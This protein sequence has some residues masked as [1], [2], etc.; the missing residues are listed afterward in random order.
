[1]AKKYDVF[2]SYSRKDSRIAD[3]IYDNLSDAGVICFIDRSDI[4]LGDEYI[5]RLYT[6]INESDIVLYLASQ[7]SYDS[8]WTNKELTYAIKKKSNRDIMPY[9]ID[10]ALMPEDKAFLLS[11]INICKMSEHSV[12]EITGMIK[13]RLKNQEEYDIYIAGHRRNAPEIEK[14]SEL[15]TKYGYKCFFWL[16]LSFEI[17]ALSQINK[18]ILNSKLF[19]FYGEMLCGTPLGVWGSNELKIAHKHNKKMLIIVNTAHDNPDTNED[20]VYGAPLSNIIKWPLWPLDEP[21]DR[22]RIQEL[23]DKCNELI[24]EGSL[25]KNN[26]EKA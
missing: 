11:D 2:I 12:A 17:D 7:N 6:A 14:L 3:K 24:G 9:I 26:G 22:I 16:E 20:W 21:L 23:L 25:D 13:S 5:H 15:L 8:F 4:N 1:M 19:I 10:D 18:A